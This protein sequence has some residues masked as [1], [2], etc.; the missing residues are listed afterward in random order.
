VNIIG[1]EAQ[2]RK[3]GET[4]NPADETDLKHCQESHTEEC[5]CLDGTGHSLDCP[6][7]S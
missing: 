2:C 7:N 3:C 5:D 1:Y 4:F 6:A